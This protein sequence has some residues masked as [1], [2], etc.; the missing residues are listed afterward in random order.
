[1]NKGSGSIWNPNSWHWENKNY[2]EEAKKYVK[3]KILDH[4]FKKDDITFKFTDMKKLE[5]YFR[6]FQRYSYIF[7]KLS[8]ITIN[9]ILKIK[10]I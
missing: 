8:I 3:S 10:N 7:T 5:V 1:M 4:Q 9:Y 6:F 2:T